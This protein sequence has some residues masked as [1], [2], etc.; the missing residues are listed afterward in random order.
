M[1]SI[2]IKRIYEPPTGHDGYRMLVDRL[3][4]RGV[5]KEAAALDE[6]NKNIAPSTELRKWFNHKPELFEEFKS[7]YQEE[8]KYSRTELERLLTIAQQQKLCLLYGA[9]NSEMNQAVVLKSVLE[10][11]KKG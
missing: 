9:K 2:A 5:S 1:F 7:R 6:W 4:P 10:K 8:L 3:W 11:M